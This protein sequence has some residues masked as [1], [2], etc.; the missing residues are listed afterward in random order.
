MLSLSKHQSSIINY[1]WP[2]IPDYLK[3][4]MDN[5]FAE[6]IAISDRIDALNQMNLQAGTPEYRSRAKERTSLY[7]KQSEAFKRYLE[8]R[9]LV[10]KALKD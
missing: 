9:S 8:A 3:E 10:S 2:M 5:A 6:V 4:R 1:Q 7:K